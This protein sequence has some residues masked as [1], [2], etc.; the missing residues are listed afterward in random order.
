M[1]YTVAVVDLDDGGR[2][3]GWV[4]DTIS[5]EQA[6]IGLDVQVVPRVFEEI[7]P[8]KVF[9]TVERAGTTWRKAPE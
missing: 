7:E 3:L 4:G 9:Y 1:P 5:E 6:K 8:I 2:L